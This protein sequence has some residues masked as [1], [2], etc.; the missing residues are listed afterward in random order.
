MKSIKNLLWKSRNAFLLKKNDIPIHAASV[1]NQILQDKTFLN[2]S[3][4]QKSTD[5]GGK[6]I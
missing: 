6:F 1:I 5:A 3:K 2:N 4:L